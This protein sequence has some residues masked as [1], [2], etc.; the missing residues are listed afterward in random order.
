MIEDRRILFLARVQ[1]Q[2]DALHLARTVLDEGAV[3]GANAI[4]AYLEG[5]HGPSEVWKQV[6]DRRFQQDAKW[7]GSAHDDH[8]IP[9]DWIEFISR[10]LS[11]AAGFNAAV[12]PDL[13]VVRDRFIDAAALAIAAIESLDRN[14]KRRASTEHFDGGRMG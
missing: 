7:G 4:V 12:P 14:R 10:Q 6:S 11:Q 3:A 8:H 13:D 2:G 1:I 5:L 9:S